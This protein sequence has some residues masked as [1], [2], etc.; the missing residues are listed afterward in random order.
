MN[1]VQ[2]YIELLRVYLGVRGSIPFEDL[3]MGS[4]TLR[5]WATQ[6]GHA[7]LR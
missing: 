3:V 5:P 4:I 2:T 6:M 7:E 1:E